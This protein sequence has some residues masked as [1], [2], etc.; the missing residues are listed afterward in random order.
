MSSRLMP[1]KPPGD[2]HD[3]LHELVRVLGVHEHR[4][5][6]DVA[7]GL[8][9]HRLALHHRQG[10]ERAD[11]A[12]PE[13]RGAVGDD[14]HRVGLDG[15]SVGGRRVVGDQPADVG[16][17]GGVDQRQVARTM[18]LPGHLDAD[19]AVVVG[20]QHLVG[21]REQFDALELHEF[22]GDLVGVDRVADLHA[23]VTEGDVPLL[24]GGVRADQFRPPRLDR[25]HDRSEGTPAPDRRRRG[26]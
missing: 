19:L 7:E 14:R 20:S 8:Q 11:V 4:V 21:D 17:A 3:G 22:R 5:G 26:R 25:S 12:E 9:Q 13:H 24:T 2:P 15:E 18:D 10:G 6:V 23:E 16:D 1:P